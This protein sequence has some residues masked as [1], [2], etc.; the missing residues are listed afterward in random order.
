M[1]E[2]THKEKL[3]LA[4]IRR[5]GSEEAWR[6]AQAKSG[7]KGGKTTGESKIRGDKE[8]YARIGE[9]GR[10]VRKLELNK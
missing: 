3:R 9:K 1:A 2:L 4:G 8:Y 5:Y 7:S 6:E 10:K